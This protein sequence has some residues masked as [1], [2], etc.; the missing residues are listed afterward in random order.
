MGYGSVEFSE[1]KGFSIFT[2]GVPL[3][4]NEGINLKPATRK[5]EQR[6]NILHAQKFLDEVLFEQIYVSPEEV[7]SYGDSYTAI[8]TVN[9]KF[10]LHVVMDDKGN[11]FPSLMTGAEKGKPKIIKFEYEG[12]QLDNFFSE[13]KKDINS[14]KEK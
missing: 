12:V 10:F 4:S 14:I 9:H 2:K 13:I 11:I 7:S 5:S 3:K 1:C 6:K 8:F